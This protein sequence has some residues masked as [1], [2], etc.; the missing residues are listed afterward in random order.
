MSGFLAVYFLIRNYKIFGFGFI[1]V[2]P[3]SDVQKFK[4]SCSYDWFCT[5]AENQQRRGPARVPV[6]QNRGIYVADYLILQKL[7]IFVVFN[8][9]PVI[10]SLSVSPLLSIPLP[11]IH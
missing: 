8:F 6:H 5:S 4:N 7:F 10:L 2:T 3:A 1:Y 9:F 11:V